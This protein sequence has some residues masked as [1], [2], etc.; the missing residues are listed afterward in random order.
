MQLFNYSNNKLSDLKEKPFKLEK[1]I[2][3]LFESNL[4]QFTGLEF[5]KS[6]CVIKNSRIDTL[7][8]DPETKAF[9][10]I[11][12]KREQNYSVVDQ[13]VSYLNLMLE[14]KDNFIVE[15]NEI[16]GDTLK[17][18]DIDWSQTRM[19]FVSP[20]FTDFQ[21]QATNFK[22]FGIELWEIKRFEHDIIFVNPIQKARSA[23]TIKQIHTSS[24]SEIN[25][26][27][28]EIKV[29]EE[30]DHFVD[31]SDDIKELYEQ[32]RDAILN[33]SSDLQIKV[34]KLYLAFKK[35][36]R[37]VTDIKIQNKG[38]KISIN[39]SKGMLDDPKGIAKD[40]SHIGHWGNGDYEINISDTKDLEYIMS[41]VKQA[42]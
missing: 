42:L 13:G 7:A 1:E 24:S 11:E 2:Q 19:L 9:V 10:I 27:S 41:L 39:L 30:E 12:Y 40:M 16:K 14:Y 20:G 4:T 15:Y 18:K 31:K 22:D 3:S 5:V 28:K 32:Y 26:I 23:P 21:K 36:K 33:L 35:D 25:K 38:L 29:Y 17:R 34:T 6:E 37:N 8:F